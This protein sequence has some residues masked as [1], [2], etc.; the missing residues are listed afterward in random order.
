[1]VHDLRKASPLKS[2]LT[3]AW[4][5]SPSNVARAELEASKAAAFATLARLRAR[6][7]K[8]VDLPAALDVCEATGV[9]AEALRRVWSFVFNFI[10]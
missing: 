2:V 1:M 10:Y 6:A 7:Q 3:G 4:H 8:Y 9:A 5:L